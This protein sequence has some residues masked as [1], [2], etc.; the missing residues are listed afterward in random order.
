[1]NGE[2]CL[3][4]LRELSGWL[5]TSHPRLVLWRCWLGH[6]TCKISP[7]KWHIMCCLTNQAKLVLFSFYISEMLVFWH[8]PAQT[9]QYYCISV[10][11]SVYV[12]FMDCNEMDKYITRFFAASC[13]LFPHYTLGQILVCFM[14]N[15]IAKCSCF[16][17]KNPCSWP[18]SGC[19]FETKHGMHIVTIEK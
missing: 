11:P 13:L 12:T 17:M 16:S 18:I 2:V 8:W 7:L 5:L 15:N 9:L 14:L 3:M 19:S 4:R 1:M 6:Q 10:C